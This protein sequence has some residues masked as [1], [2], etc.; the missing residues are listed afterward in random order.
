MHGNAA[1]G[2][3]CYC[4]D[5]SSDDERCGACISSVFWCAGDNRSLGV[6]GTIFY[7]GD[8]VSNV[9]E[10]SWTDVHS[11][12]LVQDLSG[13]YSVVSD[14]IQDDSPQYSEEEK[15]QMTPLPERF[16]TTEVSDESRQVMPYK[17]MANSSDSFTNSAGVNWLSMVNYADVWTAPPYDN[18]ERKGMNSR[19]PY[20]TDEQGRSNNC[21]NFASQAV[22][23]AGLPTDFTWYW[24]FHP[25]VGY[26]S[27]KSWRIAEDH[28][29]YMYE[30]SNSYYIIGDEWK[31]TMGSFLYFDRNYYDS[32]EKGE[33]PL[34]DHVMIVVGVASTSNG[35]IPI[36]DQKSGNRHQLPLTQSKA[37][38]ERDFPNAVWYA[39]QFKND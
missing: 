25:T 24:G 7:V 33:T 9:L 13:N 32:K 12:V 23:A 35:P 8:K 20:Y 1:Y 5:R 36:I 37:I 28:F 15:R 3:C 18:D 2:C 30:K 6:D 29:R 17:D 21:A 27:S 38:L 19:F 4:F 26:T 31:A 39:L 34:I 11:L 10:S 22:Y 16:Q 14:F